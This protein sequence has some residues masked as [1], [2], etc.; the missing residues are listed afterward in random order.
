MVAEAHASELSP[1]CLSAGIASH[2]DPS[3]IHAPRLLTTMSFG[4]SIGDFVA[5]G[6][7]IV[8]IST[9]LQAISGAKSEYQELAREL[10]SL[11]IA[12]RHLDRLACETIPSPTVASIKYT[13]LSCRVPLQE[14]LSKIKKYEKSLGVWSRAGAIK[15][16]ADKLRWTFGHNDD[17]KRLQTYLNVHIGTINILLAEHGL[18]EMGINGRKA[19][20]NTQHVRDQLANT[21]VL[22]ESINKDLPA[23][24]MLL[25]HVNSMLGGLYKLVCG[26]MRT[27]L[28]HFSQ[29]INK[30]W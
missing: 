7:L 5:V 24:G 13:A 1:A 22:L 10:Q 14:F 15:T 23:Q 16:A 6:K 19:E 2:I 29:V 9:S 3:T 21:Q 20:A 27:S 4:F 18:E 11:D 28:Q 8:E 12:L 17:T 26:E 25:R 30:V